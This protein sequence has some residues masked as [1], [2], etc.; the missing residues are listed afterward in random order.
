MWEEH[1]E[2]LIWALLLKGVSTGW[3]V[4]LVSFFVN[5]C[6][7]AAI[8]VY[9][10]TNWRNNCSV[11]EDANSFDWTRCRRGSN[12]T[13]RVGFIPS[14]V[15]MWPRFSTSL[16]A[17]W[18]LDGLTSMLASQRHAN[19]TIFNHKPAVTFWF[20]TLCCFVHCF[21]GD[22]KIITVISLL[23]S[24]KLCVSYKVH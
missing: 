16:C 9:P 10:F 22:Q 1:L 24:Q 6:W 8:V 4:N 5:E 2:M 7:G 13:R 23:H 21:S 3:K 15:M 12:G 14:S 11:Q 18:H 20:G 17:E 19:L